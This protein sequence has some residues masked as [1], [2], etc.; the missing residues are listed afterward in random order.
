MTIEAKTL[1]D[2]IAICA[3]L[4]KEGCTY[5]CKKSSDDIW[6]IKLTGGY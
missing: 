3:G 2:M 1:D 6:I 4:T 5:D